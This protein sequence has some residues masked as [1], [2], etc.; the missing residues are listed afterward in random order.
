MINNTNII[1]NSIKRM[2]PYTS[3]EI[4]NQSIKYLY[5]S[6]PRLPKPNFSVIV[7]PSLEWNKI[8]HIM[9]NSISNLNFPNNSVIF[10]YEIDDSNK[11]V[12]P[13]LNSSILFSDKS[14][15]SIEVDNNVINNILSIKG[16]EITNDLKIFE[17]NSEVLSCMP[18]VT[19]VCRIRKRGAALCTPILFSK[20]CDRAK[21]TLVLKKL[22][23]E[24]G[25]GVVIINNNLKYN[26]KDGRSTK[27]IIQNISLSF[28]PEIFPLF[29]DEKY[30]GI[31]LATYL[32]HKF[33]N[34]MDIIYEG[35]YN[36]NN[37]IIESFSI[38]INKDKNYKKFNIYNINT[39]KNIWN[40]VINSFKQKSYI[41]IG[42]TGGSYIKVKNYN[43]NYIPYNKLS[44]NKMSDIGES[45]WNSAN[46]IFD[47]FPD[48]DTSE[49]YLELAFINDI[50]NIKDI[51]NL[52]KK[53]PDKFNILS[54]EKTQHI[55]KVEE[56][57]NKTLNK[58]SI[59]KDK[60]YLYEPETISLPL[61]V[62]LFLYDINIQ[63]K[64]YEINNL[65]K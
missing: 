27:D 7:T 46:G 45:I 30:S 18:F 9:G 24:K 1:A 25:V 51:R 44:F 49:Y 40:N 42:N 28:M 41:K 3:Q 22:I 13:P 43:N 35:R 62:I 54:N 17:N 20:N 52:D 5:L 32:A 36:E 4:I 11:I 64:K 48:P 21:L 19:E 14:S 59:S 56:S 15:T 55:F 65:S 38:G 60:A 39:R 2:T 31:T 16:S 8:G 26:I 29:F 23:E 6:V 33:N 61:D 57:I 63:E 37:N 50:K 58:F 53:I 47:E 34:S 10:L 12:L